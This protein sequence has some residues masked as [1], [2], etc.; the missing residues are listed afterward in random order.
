[1]LLQ[2]INHF[3]GEN[4]KK[5]KPSANESV[6]DKEYTEI[7]ILNEN[8]ELSKNRFFLQPA[9][10]GEVDNSFCSKKCCVQYDK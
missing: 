7:T 9:L 3:V 2:L 10:Q 5:V 4:L 8:I 1:M 6:Q